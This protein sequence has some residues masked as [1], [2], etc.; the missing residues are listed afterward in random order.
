MSESVTV[1]GTALAGAVMMGM[2]CGTGCSPAISMFLSSYVVHTKGNGLE[3][4]KG[5]FRFFI[6]KATAILVV[7]VLSALFGQCFLTLDGYFNQYSLKWLM[8]LFFIISGGHM[9]RKSIDEFRGIS[10]KNC[11]NHK[12]NHRTLQKYSPFAGGFLYGLT[13]CAPLVL[14]AGYALT[15][16]IWQ[17]ILLGIVFSLA[18]MISPMIF[19]LIIMR[20]ITVNVLEEV[21]GLFRTLKL[22]ISAA[23]LVSGLLELGKLI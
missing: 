7:C 15:M 9:I 16:T 5:F 13:P 4:V 1:F 11:G 21:P 8:P 18:C 12:A 20:M 19:I 10:C 3:S 23:V 6:G 14:L 17:A 22:L 2:T